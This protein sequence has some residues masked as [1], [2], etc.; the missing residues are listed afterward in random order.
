MIS[1]RLWEKAKGRTLDSVRYLSLNYNPLVNDLF[2][3]SSSVRW[4][5][6]LELGREIPL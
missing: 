6:A 3:F 4:S 5:A 2:L 1:G